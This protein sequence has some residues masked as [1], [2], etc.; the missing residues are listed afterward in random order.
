MTAR[1]AL[2]IWTLALACAAV[3]IAL[4][5]TGDHTDGKVALIAL[6]VP[7]ELAFVAS[8]IVARLQRPHNR[9][10]VL[11]ILV[12]FS[13]FLGA[14]TTA[15]NPYVFTTGLVVGTVFSALLAHLFLAFPTGRLATRV[16]RV[17]AGAFYG[18]VLI[19]PTLAYVFDE[20]ELTEA[21]CDGPC[22]DNV[23]AFAPAQTVA[24]A[25]TVAYGVAAAV[26]AL[27]V[28]ARLVLRW[29]RASPALRRALA[30]VLAT[31]GVLIGLVVAQTL[32]AL[33]STEAAEAINWLV[34]GA[35]LAVPLSFLYGLLR[36][37]FGATTRRLV[38]ELSE[39]RAPEEVQAVLRRALRDATLE[40]GYVG[41]PDSGYVGVDERPLEL[42]GADTDRMV[43]RIGEAIIVHDASLR[44]QPELD[45]VVHA[46][47]IA[48][49]RG[50]TLR[51][52][53]ES[54]RRARAVLDA[55]PD[56][57]YRLSTD[58][59]FLEPPSLVGR[60][61][62]DVLPQISDVVLAGVRRA[63]AANEV[64]SVEYQFTEANDV[65][66][67][68]ARIV[69]SGDDEV[70]GI[71]RD[72]TE[73]R[74]QEADL[75]LLVEEQAALNRVA[76][77]VATETSPQRVFDVVT[78]EVARLLG[79]DGANL[80]RFTPSREQA[81]IVG[82]WSEPGVRIPGSG[83]VDIP[84]GSALSRV[85]RTGAPARMATDDPGVA[86]ELHERLTALGCDLSRRRAD[87]RVRGHLG[88]RRRLD[89]G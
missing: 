22:P 75:R 74:R 10:G 49:E 66:D 56:H 84:D 42:P 34:L 16:D 19:G 51:S 69:R 70:V 25:I 33:V 65:R 52:L 4:I 44:E 47:R 38:A 12:G 40:L 21:V 14:L 48:L 62:D 41:A 6:A 80:V 24:T 71:V 28:L 76:V 31:A 77:T 68:E 82:K 60:R 61:I 87:R 7:T 18:V 32:L 81:V 86:P 13:W 43:T 58:G 50:L 46:A 57:V 63:L 11:L 79:A 78:E 53:E 27:L 17:L 73:R 23:L 26:L 39:K 89:D 30:P 2:G 59:T 72:V 37:R 36:S 88:R 83:T 64:V 3:A 85:A 8:G 20:G 67:H 29:R 54:E 15:G 35:V 9:T 5:A 55:I 45:E 1:A